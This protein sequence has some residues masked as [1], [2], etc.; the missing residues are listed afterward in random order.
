MAQG[1][2]PGARDL[3][4]PPAAAVVRQASHE[5]VPQIAGEPLLCQWQ[6]WR[7]IVSPAKYRQRHSCLA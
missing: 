4:R 6:V 5:I 2:A 1:D 7:R 3:G